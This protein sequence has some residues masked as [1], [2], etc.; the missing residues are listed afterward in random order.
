MDNG[1]TFVNAEGN[2]AER[3][4]RIMLTESVAKCMI[5][6]WAVSDRVILVIIKENPFNIYLI[7]VFS[8]QHNTKKMKW[9][10][11]IEKCKVLNVSVNSMK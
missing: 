11:S 5:G 10:N 8:Q 7:Q 4:V 3:G 2:T 9:I 6:Y 1:G